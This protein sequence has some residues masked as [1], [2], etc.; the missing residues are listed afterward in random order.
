[1]QRSASI[2][3][4]SS[5]F[6]LAAAAAHAAPTRVNF[7]TDP[8][9]NPIASG[10]SVNNTYAS[11]G[12]T[13]AKDGG[14][15]CGPNIYASADQ[16]PGFGSAPNVVTTCA[17][18]ISSDIDASGYGVIK[19][20]L[21]RN[22][23]QVC[24]DVRPDGPTHGGG[25]RVYNAA[26]TQIGMA[27]SVPGL[28]QQICATA[29]GIRYARIAGQDV[30]SFARFDNLSVNFGGG[31][32]TQSYYQGIAAMADPRC[33]TAGGGSI[34][35]GTR[36]WVWNT[37]S[38][39]ATITRVDAVNGIAQG[40]PASY[41]AN[42]GSGTQDYGS[43][44]ASGLGNYPFTYTLQEA[45]T[46]GG[47]VV[48]VSAVAVQCE[49]DGQ[50]GVKYWVGLAPPSLENPQASS[51]QS[52][53]GLI[54]G[55]SCVGP[56]VGVSFDG[57]SPVS[58]PYGSGRLDTASVCGAWNVYTGFGLLTNFNLLGTASHTA[59]LYVNGQA[60][61]TLRSFQVT[62]PAGEF[63]VGASA[64]STVPNFPSAGR[65][66]TLIWQQAQQ[67]FGIQAVSP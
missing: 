37:P 52:G 57:V 61:G 24:I 58:A 3:L 12:I 62:A 19:V 1:M 53:I 38:G 39:G 66:T 46:V 13:F 27:L 64:S 30:G 41:A 21:N 4:A 56:F 49:A 45:M 11:L 31:P 33:S 65:S 67:N 5:L 29:L 34:T 40:S 35:T 42:A 2:V 60:F 36:T 26:D 32:A 44:G 28:T 22:A 54:S 8:N 51:Y 20:T 14:G 6:V 47:N 9:G 50:A 43:F 17:P 55:W 23:T 48:S 25:M 18:P 10:T 63:L 15:S 59:Q 7:D 16:P